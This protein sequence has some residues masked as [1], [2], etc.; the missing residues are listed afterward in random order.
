MANNSQWS[1]AGKTALVTGASKGIGLAAS[2]EMLALGAELVVVA[3]G[4]ETLEQEFAKNGAN[5][6]KVHLVAADVTDAQ[7]RQKVFDKLPQSANSIS[8]S[9]TSAPI[10][11]SWLTITA[12]MTSHF[13][14]TRMSPQL[15]RFAEA[16][17]NG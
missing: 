3:R 5:N 16:C 9:T 2:K 11:E 6:A 4:M 15:W 14:S 1:L 13:C 10:F 12:R 7:G 17:T 8:W